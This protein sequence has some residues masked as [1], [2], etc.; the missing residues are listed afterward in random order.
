MDILKI[1]DASDREG[2]YMQLANLYING[3]EGIREFIYNN[4]DFGVFW[5]LPNQRQLACN[6]NQRWSSIERIEAS[7]CYTVLNATE[8]NL[9]EEL[10]GLALIYNSCLVANLDPTKIFNKIAMI[11]NLE[12]KKVVLNFLDRTDIDKSLIA[13]H[14]KSEINADNEI[15]ISF[16]F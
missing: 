14:L 7:L 15:E 3:N 4:W 11:A 5:I 16:N 9:R 13:F 10:I 12:S 2:A 1:I 6:K 8:E